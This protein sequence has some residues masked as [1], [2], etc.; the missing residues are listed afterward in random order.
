VITGD[1]EYLKSYADASREVESELA[2]LRDLIKDN[3]TERRNLETLAVVAGQRL[4]FLGETVETRRGQSFE[5]ARGRI[6][7]GKAKETGE[8]VRSAASE[9]EGEERRL[10]QERE[11]RAQRSSV[12]TR[13]TNERA[14]DG[15]EPSVPTAASRADR[16]GEQSE[17]RCSR[18]GS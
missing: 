4:S 15:S 1:E 17:T 16:S 9:I 2:K 14:S 11:F 12:I 7:S 6:L 13:M 8:Q 10:L 3:A 5:A 18:T